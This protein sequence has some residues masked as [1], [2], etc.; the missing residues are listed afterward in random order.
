MHGLQLPLPRPPPC[1][2]LTQGFSTSPPASR[3][4]TP[5]R[6]GWLSQRGGDGGRGGPKGCPGCLVTPLNP[7]PLPSRE[8]RDSG[9]PRGWAR[10]RQ[11]LL[12]AALDPGPHAAPGLTACF[13]APPIQF[14]PIQT[15]LPPQCTR[16]QLQPRCLPSSALLLARVPALTCSDDA[17]GWKNTKASSRQPWNHV[18]RGGSVSRE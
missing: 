13:P 10:P 15:N 8:D 5:E 3:A 9:S 11:V 17:S 1:P 14:P 18:T 7:T 2:A 6:G 4:E 16:P 12:G